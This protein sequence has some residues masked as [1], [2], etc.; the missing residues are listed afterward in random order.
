[1]FCDECF[2]RVFCTGSFVLVILRRWWSSAGG[3]PQVVLCKWFCTGGFV[4]L[5]SHRWLA[6]LLL[7]TIPPEAWSRA[8]RKARPTTIGDDG[9]DASLVLWMC[10]CG[11]G[12]GSGCDV[13]VGLGVG[14]WVSVG[15][16][17]GKLLGKLL[18]RR[19]GSCWD[20]R[21]GSSCG[22]CY[23][24]SRSERSEA[25]RGRFWQML[26]QRYLYCS[27]QESCWGSRWGSCRGSC[28][29]SCW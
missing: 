4:Q 6:M 14:V 26:E 2:V 5:F 13:G 19:R 27:R 9:P 28:S 10:G 21:W 17:V 23:A 20:S 25:E 12:S 18:V 11:S 8:R 15:K 24:K 1:M 16:L 29:G 7:F 22:S 3:V